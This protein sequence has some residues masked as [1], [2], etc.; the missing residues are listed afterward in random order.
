MEF[1]VVVVAFIAITV[2][3]FLRAFSVFDSVQEITSVALL[4]R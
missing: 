1:A 3:E 4:F 2:L